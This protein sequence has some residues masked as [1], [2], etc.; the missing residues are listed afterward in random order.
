MVGDVSVK[1][2]SLIKNS[3]SLSLDKNLCCFLM[4]AKQ[5]GNFS[6]Y[7]HCIFPS[8][9]GARY[10]GVRKKWKVENFT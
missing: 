6:C 10:E 2:P 7:F 5:A 3:C 4:A 1:V 9:E 8:W